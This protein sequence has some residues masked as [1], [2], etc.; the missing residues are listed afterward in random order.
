MPA[1]GWHCKPLTAAGEQGRGL[2]CS[3]FIPDYTLWSGVS[4][5]FIRGQ[6]TV[7]PSTGT[8]LP[9]RE[10]EQ[11]ERGRESGEE[12]EPRQEGMERRET[13]ECL[14]Y[15]RT[16]FY[17]QIYISSTWF[18]TLVDS[19]KSPTLLVPVQFRHPPAPL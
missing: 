15:C 7:L 10:E 4:L 11:R 2:E 14:S 9:P 17:N 19:K 18:V 1:L 5:L 16:E 13:K 12:K 8:G 6:H 3:L